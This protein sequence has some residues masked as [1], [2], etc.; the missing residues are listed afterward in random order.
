MC[1]IFLIGHITF[2]T[3]YIIF[4]NLGLPFLTLWEPFLNLC[5][6]FLILLK[7]LFLVIWHIIEQENI[8]YSIQPGEQNFKHFYIELYQEQNLFFNKI[9]KCILCSWE[10][11]M[12]TQNLAEAYDNSTNLHDYR[13]SV[14]VP[15]PLLYTSL[16]CSCHIYFINP[17]STPAKKGEIIRCFGA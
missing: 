15:E 10:Q 13:L 8:F 14:F 5:K 16:P 7:N 17:F 2:L 9:E 1:I 12:E 11:V 4:M 3:K 6:S